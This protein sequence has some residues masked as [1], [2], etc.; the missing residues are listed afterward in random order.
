M[1]ASQSTYED[2]EVLLDEGSH[3]RRK[4]RRKGSKRNKNR[5]RKNK[6]RQKETNSFTA[7]A[8]TS[9]S[10]NY[11]TGLGEYYDDEDEYY[12]RDD[13]YGAPHAPAYSAPSYE[14][15]S[16]QTS[17]SYGAPSYGGGGDGF[18]DFLNALA[19]FLPIGLFLAAI[20]PNLITVST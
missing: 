4:Y 17:D 9:D 1:Q 5:K 3:S 8:F 11:G 7:P 14:A 13:G 2:E 15:P 12:D 18:N 10:Y 6:H 19:A 20:P 16:Y